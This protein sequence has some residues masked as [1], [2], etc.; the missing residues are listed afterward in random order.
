VSERLPKFLR[1]R[2]AAARQS[3]PPEKSPQQYLDESREAL[4]R[5]Y[6]ERYAAD[7]PTNPMPRVDWDTFQDMVRIDTADDPDPWGIEH[8]E[9]DV[10]RVTWVPAPPDEDLE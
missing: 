9:R 10:K 7:P 5:L 1:R 3:Q 2:A 8:D 6:P 4:A